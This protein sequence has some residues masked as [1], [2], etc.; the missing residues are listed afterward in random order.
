M[1][2]IKITKIKEIKSMLNQVNIEIDGRIQGNIEN[3]GT[4]TFDL[5]P[6][7]HV[8]KAIISLTTSNSLEVD[9]K[10]DQTI[11][12]KLYHRKGLAL[13]NLLFHSKDYLILEKIDP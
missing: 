3:G 1:A 13:L 2:S 8:I 11:H 7:K 9:L 10:E 4:T 12:L 6:G 5:P